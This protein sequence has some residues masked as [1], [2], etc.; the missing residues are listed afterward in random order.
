MDDL[1][2]EIDTRT[3]AVSRHFRLARGREHG[4]SG[5]P[6]ARVAG[7]GAAGHDMSGH[8]LTVP[9]GS[10]SCSPTWVQPSA[11]GSRLYVACSRSSDVVEIDVAR[12][13]MTRRL[14][15]GDGVYNLAATR[16][17]RLLVTTN[18]R[19]QS[20]SV[21]DL[22]TGHELARI[23][24]SRRVA[25][26]VAISAD[27]RYA[28][29]TCEGVGAEPGSVDVIDLRTLRRVASLDVGQQAGGIDVWTPMPAR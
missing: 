7:A 12:W 5:P 23:A 15:A 6:P 21:I 3:L 10:V 14:P 2:V 16:D 22:S 8:A 26:G 4:E 17:G 13:T 29:V 20:A 25:S 1:A 18:K 27:D 24:T 28:F 11:D 19:G 9:A